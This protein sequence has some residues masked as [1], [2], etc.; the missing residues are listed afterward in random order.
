MANINVGDLSI[1]GVILR[2]YLM[3]AIVI[4]IG[5]FVSL[6]VAAIVDLGIAAS[7]ILG[8]SIRQARKNRQAI[9]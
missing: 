8:V 1:A 6:T 9:A 5:F 2:F 3:M 7:F 4:A